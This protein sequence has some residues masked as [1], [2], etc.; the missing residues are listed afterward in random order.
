MMDLDSEIVVYTAQEIAELLIITPTTVR[1]WI[2]DGKLEAIEQNSYKDGFV[3]M[4]YN[5][6]E[7]LSKNPG[8]YSKRYMIAKASGINCGKETTI[9]DYI[10]ECIY[11]YISAE[12]FIN[13]CKC[14]L[15]G[16][17]YFEEKLREIL[18]NEGRS[19]DLHKRG[20]DFV[21]KKILSQINITL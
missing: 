21:V 5:L 8:K 1:T 17:T 6:E 9:K 7:F 12:D 14:S 20:K 18:Q 13:L 4:S 11:K 10:L 15:L 3:I 19:F 2:N 16:P